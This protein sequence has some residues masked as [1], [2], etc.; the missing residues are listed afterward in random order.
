MVDGL[1]ISRQCTSTTTVFVKNCNGKKQWGMD[2]N[3]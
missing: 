2:A 1:C 3:N